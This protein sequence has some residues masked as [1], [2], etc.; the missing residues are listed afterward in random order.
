M[1]RLKVIDTQTGGMYG[2]PRLATLELQDTVRVEKQ[3]NC[4]VLVELDLGRKHLFN[5]KG[6]YLETI[7]FAK[8][9]ANVWLG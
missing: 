9:K 7:R 1:I 3:D 5:S 2:S 8:E 4:L 6:E